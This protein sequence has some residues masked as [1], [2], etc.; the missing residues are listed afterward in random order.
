MQIAVRAAAAVALLFVASA[1]PLLAAGRIFV[2]WKVLD[3]GDPATESMFVLYWVPS[4]PDEMRKSDL[5]TSRPL[6][7]YSS[8]CVAMH[9]VRVDD[10]E[11]VEALGVGKLPVVILVQDGGEVAR[12]GGDGTIFRAG[13]VES[14]IDDVFAAREAAAQG[15]LDRGREL[16]KEGD[17][18]QAA[19]LF[20]RVSNCRCAFPKLARQAEKALARIK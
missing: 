1:L 18:A 13:D 4:S 9:V 8:R 14:M 20:E 19:E 12:V 11:R 17:Q 16:V 7:I 2:P 3:A 10:G 6:A 15:D 5:L